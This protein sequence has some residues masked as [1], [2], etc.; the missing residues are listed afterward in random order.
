[1]AILRDP[2]LL[3]NLQNPETVRKVAQHHRA[4][5]EASENIVKALKS[6][7]NLNE[8]VSALNQESFEDLSDSSSSSS[9]SGSETSPR[10]STSNQ[11][12]TA[13]QFQR[14]L[15]AAQNRNSLAN[16]SQRINQGS[17]ISPSTS[18]GSVPT[19]HRFI[20]SSMFMNAMNE[21]L[22][23]NRRANENPTPILTEPAPADLPSERESTPA[24]EPTED[25]S[26]D[27][28]E[29]RNQEERD[30]EMITNFQPQLRQMEELGLSNKA[31][32]IQALMLCNGNIEA[33]INLVLT[34]NNS[35]MMD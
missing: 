29:R 9:S 19:S 18:S 8:P 17:A 26:M 13:E 20:S 28:D 11:R 12:I 25:V 30:I 21:V 35:N 1:M 7:K 22:M 27:D 5:I 31:Q 34:E 23:A 15:A 24:N 32:N 14:S 3:S 16:I 33:A 4:L 6:A 10:A 2:I